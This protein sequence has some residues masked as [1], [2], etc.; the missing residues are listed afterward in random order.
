MPRT[1]LIQKSQDYDQF[2]FLDSN[3]EI[4]RGHVENIKQA[5][6]DYGNFTR[7]QPILVNENLE[8]IDGQHRFTACV[9][10]GEP[11]YYTVAPGLR[12]AEARKMNI[13]QKGWGLEDYAT[14][15]AKENNDSYQR[16][17]QLVDEF[18][19]GHSTTILYAIGREYSGVYKEFREG[20][21]ELSEEQLIGAQ[22]RLGKLADVGVLVPFV[23]EKAFTRAFLKAINVEGYDHARMLRKLELHQ[24]LLERKAS[25]E[26]YLRLI[27]DI[28]NHQMGESRR[29]RLY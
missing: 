6:E 13:L 11:V 27:E 4:N 21:F 22:E 9:E 23:R 16:Y 14:S 29:L 3:R 1:N 5:F 18:G 10:R 24:Q 7:V 20:G 15:F 8:I 26:D 17:L 12:I 19:F 2:S 25:P 28:Y